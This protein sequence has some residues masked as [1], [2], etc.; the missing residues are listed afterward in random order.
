MHSTVQNI[1]T[2]SVNW[3]INIL[4]YNTFIITD[5]VWSIYKYYA[6]SNAINHR[7]A[8]KQS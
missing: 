6:L 3:Y 5:V 1:E 4:L 7:F 2:S 8:C